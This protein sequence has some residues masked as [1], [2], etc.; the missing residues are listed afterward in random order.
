MSESIW[1]RVLDH[2]APRQM[3]GTTDFFAKLSSL[4]GLRRQAEYNTGSIS[5]ASQWLLYALALYLAPRVI[6]EVGTF[7]GKSTLALAFGLDAADVEGEIHTCDASNSME[8]PCWTRCAVLQYQSCPST[9]MF[10]ELR[11]DGYEG[12]VD[13]LHLDGRLQ[14][15]DLEHVNALCAPNAVFVL[16][17]YEGI[18]KGVANAFAVRGITRFQGYLTAYPPTDRLLQRFGFLDRST[19]A[20]MY[21]SSLLRM[22][23]Q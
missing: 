11:E 21:P 4:D 7:I 17:D 23:A 22:T 19:T 8:L 12:K 15:A 3:A 5:T 1:T 13:V 6:V 18:E 14:T 16:D 20:L 10:E 9:R 2:A